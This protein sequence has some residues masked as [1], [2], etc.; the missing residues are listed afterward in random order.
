MEASTE[1]KQ[2]PFRGLPR[3]GRVLPPIY[4]AAAASAAALALPAD[5]TLILH[6]SALWGDVSVLA[7]GTPVSDIDLLVLAPRMTSLRQTARRLRELSTALGL[8]LS[9]FCRLGVKF[10]LHVELKPELLTAN[11]VSALL[12][13]QLLRGE[14]PI[15][16]L[17]LT[18]S[19][20]LH[21]AWL[22]TSTR[23]AYASYQASLLESDADATALR[24]YVATR[25]VLEIATAA[26]LQHGQLRRSYS[27]RVERWEQLEPGQSPWLQSLMRAALTIKRTPD[28]KPFV[29]IENAR[30][31]LRAW[32][33]DTLRTAPCSAKRLWAVYR[34]LDGRDGRI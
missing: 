28:A 23:L 20:Y 3:R 19:W 1:L 34:P 27:E 33:R 26:L 11:E 16:A 24:N 9:T 8:P 14:I 5:T 25:V 29:S 18:E 31:I 15:R 12:H 6:G 21:Q 17:Q 4:A 7:D 32:T 2:R 30:S 13:G 22:S 10:R